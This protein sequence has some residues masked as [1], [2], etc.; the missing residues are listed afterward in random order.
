MKTEGPYENSTSN[1]LCV[2]E[3]KTSVRMKCVV[4]GSW[5]AALQ[6]RRV[7]AEVGAGTLVPTSKRNR[8]RKVSIQVVP[9]GNLNTGSEL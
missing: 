3:V 1:I 5:G 7:L 2:I 9:R 6:L 8:T 4:V